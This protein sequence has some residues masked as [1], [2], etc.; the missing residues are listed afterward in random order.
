[1]RHQQK[2]L[3]SPHG[4]EG[5]V[6]DLSAV[7]VGKGEVALEEGNPGGITVNNGDASSD[8]GQVD[9]VAVDPEATEG[10]PVVEDTREEELNVQHLVILF[11]Y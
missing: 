3:C 5:I 2:P 1:L 7:L 10:V 11:A 4:S 6:A 9:F 8:E